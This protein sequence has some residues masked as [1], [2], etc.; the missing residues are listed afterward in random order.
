MKFMI[1]CFGYGIENQDGSRMV[2][3]RTMSGSTFPVLSCYVRR[4]SGLW[5]TAIV[6]FARPCVAYVAKLNYEVFEYV[7]VHP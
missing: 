6:W 2:W 7:H 4:E 1:T 3:G 5:L